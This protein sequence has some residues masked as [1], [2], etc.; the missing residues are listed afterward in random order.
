MKKVIFDLRYHLLTFCAVA[1]CLFRTTQPHEFKPV[2]NPYSEIEIIDTF[3]K[4]L[5]KDLSSD[6]HMASFPIG[7]IG[8][9]VKQINNYN[10]INFR[11]YDRPLK[12]SFRN[13]NPTDLNIYVD[14]TRMIGRTKTFFS[15]P[16]PL[17]TLKDKKLSKS[18]IRN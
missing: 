16:P 12:K 6:F 15:S 4:Y 18:Y 10:S 14:T 2:V 8:P 5:E 13:A 7:Y 1:F 9:K 3:T 17:E 11:D